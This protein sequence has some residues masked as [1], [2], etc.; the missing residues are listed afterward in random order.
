MDALVELFEHHDLR[1][2]AVVA[3]IASLSAVSYAVATVDPRGCI[4]RADPVHEDGALEVTG[5]QGHIGRRA[6]REPFIHLHGAFARPDGR[7]RGGHFYAATVLATAELTL[8]THAETEWSAEPFEQPSGQAA[9]PLTVLVPRPSH[10][11]S[12]P[13]RTAPTPEMKGS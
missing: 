2:A 4:G 8:L 9:D 13:D 5:L 1:G 3:G 12:S 10:P 11:T 6:D 7:M